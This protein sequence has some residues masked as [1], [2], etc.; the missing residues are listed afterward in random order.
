MQIPFDAATIIFAVLAIFVVWKLRSVLGTRVEIDKKPESP[1]LRTPLPGSA[2]Q[3]VRNGAA[4]GPLPTAKPA[5]P[6]AFSPDIDR[7][8]QQIARVDRSFEPSSFVSGAKSAYGM[9]I[10]AFAKG[11]RQTLSVLLGD[12]ALRTFM[13]SLDAREKTPATSLSHVEAIDDVQVAGAGLQGSQAQV[14]LRFKARILE[15]PVQTDPA[16][17]KPASQTVEA[18]D[19]WTFARDVRNSDPNWKLIATATDDGHVA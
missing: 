9:I 16:S 10:E 4:P 14:T 19:L 18:D 12:E 1:T 6:G 8:L 7:A 13:A 17:A 15:T 3:D 5:A 11:D 2:P